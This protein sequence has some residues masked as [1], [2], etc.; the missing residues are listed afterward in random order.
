MARRL[1][2]THGI[3]RSRG[4]PVPH[5]ASKAS[6]LASHHSGLNQR[7][8]MTEDRSSA[9]TSPFSALFDEANAAAPETAPKR[10]PVPASENTPAPRSKVSH[11]DSQ[12]RPQT[13]NEKPAEPAPQANAIVDAVVAS[14]TATANQGTTVVAG[15]AAATEPVPSADDIDA[16][17]DETIDVE[18]MAAQSAVVPAS[19]TSPA[20]TATPSLAGGPAAAPDVD[21]AAAETIGELAA[22]APNVENAP[23]LPQQPG[24]TTPEAQATDQARGHT[25]TAH[26]Q[27]KPGSA[28]APGDTDPLQVPAS[29]A[30]ATTASDT[31]HANVQSAPHQATH[32]ET[33]SRVSQRSH[34]PDAAEHAPIARPGHEALQSTQPAPD[35]VPLTHLQSGREAGATAAATAPAPSAD[36]SNSTATAPVPLQGLAVEITARAQNGGNRFEIR[37][38]PPELGRIEVRLD[39]DRSG[40]V[41]SRLVVDKVETL[42]VLRRDAHQ[43]ERALQDAGLKTSDNGLQFSLRD[44]AF[45]ERHDRGGSH[46][47]HALVADP[48]LPAADSVAVA[49]GTTLRSSGVDIRV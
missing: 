38:D 32:A 14:D 10:N 27:P 3:L 8:R 47:V 45:A 4:A 7:A 36:T 39:I 9:S 13:Q 22:V 30:P 35:T 24:E 23:D 26:A 44:Q 46:N 33:S 25:A 17:A 12:Q 5:V 2:R 21:D 28:T 43:L 6:V 41:T 31:E 20:V 11:A 48:E 16:A 29:E 42:D 37:L 15:P 19:P 1:H 34:A 18:A 49:Y 40:Q